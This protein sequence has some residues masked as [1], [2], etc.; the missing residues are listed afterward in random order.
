MK[1]IIKINHEPN[2]SD[3]KW[4]CYDV[5]FQDIDKDGKRKQWNAHLTRN[6]FRQ[7]TLK[8]EIEATNYDSVFFKETCKRIEE[9]EELAYQ[10]GVMS[11]VESNAG[12]S[13]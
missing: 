2:K 12:A 7:Q 13:L 10:R 5:T 8:E 4:A 1:T 11:E 6:E 9:L 3:S